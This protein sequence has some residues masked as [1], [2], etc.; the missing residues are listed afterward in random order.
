[1]RLAG[2]LLVVS[3]APLTSACSS[4]EDKRVFQVLNRSG[5]GHRY[6]GDATEENYAAVGDLVLVTDPLNAEFLTT[7]PQTVDID[8][9]I[10]MPEIGSVHVAGLTEGEIAALLTGLYRPY[11]DDM[12][13]SVRIKTQSKWFFVFGEV[14]KEGRHAL[15]AVGSGD[16]TVLEAAMLAGPNK[17]ISNLSRVKLIR[18]DPVDPLIIVVD[19]ERL[20]RTGDTTYNIRIRENDILIVPPTLIGAVGNALTQL[21]YPVTQVV[22]TLVSLLSAATYYQTYRFNRDY[23]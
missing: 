7:P 14:A 13:I 21:V 9:T 19:L 22:G 2:L 6:H 10:E 5:F 8:G 20:M 18:G 17:V 16:V 3:L 23:F 12:R 1:M 4:L 15:G 11:F